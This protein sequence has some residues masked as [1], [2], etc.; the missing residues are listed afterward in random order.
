MQEIA[1]FAVREDYLCLLF[2]NWKR[3]RKDDVGFNQFVADN[4]DNAV[5]N[6]GFD[7]CWVI[8]FTQ[9]D[10]K[11]KYAKLAKSSSRSKI[12]ADE[13]DIIKDQY[14]QRCFYCGKRNVRLTKDHVIPLSD[15][16]EDIPNNIVPACWPCNYKKRAMPVEVF[17]E[18]SMCKLI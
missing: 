9:W 17:K 15:G 8:F 5:V 2:K 6:L 14:N 12:K 1:E 13:W 16:G 11:D 7:V 4:P 18:G 3:Y 10:G